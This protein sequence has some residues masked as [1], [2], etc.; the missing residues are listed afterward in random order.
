[1][2]PLPFTLHLQARADIIG[3]QYITK[4]KQELHTQKCARYA[5]VQRDFSSAGAISVVDYKHFFLQVVHQCADVKVIAVPLG[6]TI[7]E[8]LLQLAVNLLSGQQVC[9]CIIQFCLVVRL[10]FF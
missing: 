4:Q 2:I 8:L 9:M 3:S 5:Y 1:M 10:S 6:F 7:P